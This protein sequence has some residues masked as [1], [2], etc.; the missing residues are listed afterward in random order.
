MIAR[1]FRQQQVGASATNWADQFQTN[2]CC[3][4]DGAPLDNHPPDVI[5]LMPRAMD[6][7]L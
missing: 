3:F 4:G 7:S 6:S 5:C 2:K 1:C